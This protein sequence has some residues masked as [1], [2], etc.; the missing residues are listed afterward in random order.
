[1]RLPDDTEVSEE[2]WDDVIEC[3]K[4]RA[5]D[6]VPAVRSFAVRSLARFANDSENSDILELL[7]EKLPLEQNGVRSLPIL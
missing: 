7:I 1:M 6:K 3:M 5:S 2:L 4:L